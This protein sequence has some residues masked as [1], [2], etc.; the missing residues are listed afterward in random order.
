MSSPEKTIKKVDKIILITLLIKV[1]PMDSIVNRIMMMIESVYMHS[2]FTGLSL[3]GYGII[4]VVQFFL[5]S[6]PRH[7][8][9]LENTLFVIFATLYEIWV[10]KSSFFVEHEFQASI[11]EFMSPFFVV[12]VIYECLT[13][14][15]LSFL[16][17]TNLI[18][19]ISLVVYSD[20]IIWLFEI[21][22]IIVLTEVLMFSVHLFYIIFDTDTYKKYAKNVLEIS[23]LLSGVLFAGTL[24]K[25]YINRNDFINADIVVMLLS[26]SHISMSLT[27]WVKCYWTF[28][29][30]ENITEEIESVTDENDD[31]EQDV[32]DILSEPITQV[33]PNEIESDPVDDDTDDNQTESDVGIMEEINIPDSVD[34]NDNDNFP[35]SQIALPEQIEVIISQTETEPI[36]DSAPEPETKPEEIFPDLVEDNATEPKSEIEP[37]EILPGAVKDAEDNN[38]EPDADNETVPEPVEDVKSPEPDPQSEATVCELDGAHTEEVAVSDPIEEIFEPEILESLD[39]Y[40]EQLEEAVI[41][42]LEMDESVDT[43]LPEHIITHPEIEII[44]TTD[45]TSTFAPEPEDQTETID[46]ESDSQEINPASQI[47][48]AKPEIDE[49]SVEENIFIPYAPQI[50][51]AEPEVE[52]NEIIPEPVED[53]STELEIE[54]EETSVSYDNQ[55]EPVAALIE[56]GIIPDPVEDSTPEPDTEGYEN[57]AREPEE[58]NSKPDTDPAPQKK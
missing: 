39:D 23:A 43:V 14:D 15:F 36:T 21:Y 32:Q 24:Y 27:Q 46:P 22:N 44:E 34:N 19:T 52:D 45:Q 29:S 9:R 12:N 37:E 6:S 50:D 35:D 54:P 41:V 13:V 49:I 11:L 56:E 31:P 33:E 48:E 58:N 57:P 30:E 16:Y 55:Y 40:L 18:C 1:R 7:I 42:E 53:S 17:Y 20:Q 47:G 38:S 5:V 8:V 26:L 28:F 2:S 10:R 51:K 25:G 4:F 3:S